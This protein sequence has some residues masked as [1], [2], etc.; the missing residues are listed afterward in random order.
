M[1]E[2]GH[3]YAFYVTPKLPLGLQTAWSTARVSR[4]IF[5]SH[6]NTKPLTQLRLNLKLKVLTIIDSHSA[7]S[8]DTSITIFRSAITEVRNRKHH[9]EEKT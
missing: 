7:I 6:G 1:Q 4:E 9:N 2:L 3:M 5:I 8:Q